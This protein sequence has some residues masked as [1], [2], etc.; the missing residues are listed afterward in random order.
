LVLFVCGCGSSGGDVLFEDDFSSGQYPGPNWTGDGVIDDAMGAPAPALFLATPPL[1]GMV[2]TQATNPVDTSHG[3]TLS[4][5]AAM[6]STAA[7]IN[8]DLNLFDVNANKNTVYVEFRPGQVR[9]YIMGDLATVVPVT[10]DTA[11][12]SY[13]VEFT[14]NGATT[15]RRD[16]AV[17][18]QGQLGFEPTLGRL[19]VRSS[20]QNGFFVDNIAIVSK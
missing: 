4:F 9:L 3:V 2:Q 8:S 17:Q 20:D 5:D 16:G 13:E 14:A 18:L 7:G 11:F 12:H 19:L 6:G 15:W 10:D 1:I